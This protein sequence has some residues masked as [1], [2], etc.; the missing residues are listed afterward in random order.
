MSEFN[1]FGA[2]TKDSIRVGYV[3]PD[4][5]YIAS[6][7]IYEANLYASKNPGAVFI[8]ETRNKIRYLSINEVNALTPKDLNVGGICPE[9][10]KGLKP[11]QTP[12]YAGGKHP[13]VV[14]GQP[15]KIGSRGGTPLTSGGRG[16]RPVTAGGQ[17]VTTKGR[18]VKVGGSGENQIRLGGT[19]GDLVYV[20]NDILTINGTEVRS[21][22]QGGTVLKFGGTDGTKVVK[23]GIN[24]CEGKIYISGGGGVGAYAVPVF[25]KDGSLLAAVVTQGGYGYKTPPQA[26]VIDTCKRGVG[27]VLKVFLGEV[28]EKEI[29]Y[30]REEDFEIYD[31]TPPEG[32]V[33]YGKRFG[34]NGEDLGEW[35]HNLFA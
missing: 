23:D 17:P 29:V 21:G 2:A 3:D 4:R 10:I 19:D 30:D 34:P 12:T 6:N 8:L 22:G 11:S 27:A 14:N 1:I 24:E 5:G 26:R 20:G 15:V 25:G 7:S 13:L 18:K 33:G 28:G 32:L 9:G 16:G 31:L 35:D